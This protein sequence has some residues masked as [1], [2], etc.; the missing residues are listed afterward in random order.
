MNFN[1]LAALQLMIAIGIIASLG[2]WAAYFWFK[3]EKRKRNDR[4]NEKLD[5]F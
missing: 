3:R 5:I 4:I 2:M 1:V